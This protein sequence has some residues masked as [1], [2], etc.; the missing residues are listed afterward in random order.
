VS[1]VRTLRWTFRLTIAA[2]VLVGLVLY[3]VNHAVAGTIC[4]F[5][6]I[7]AG[8]LSAVLPSRR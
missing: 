2:C 8:L 1:A 4:F 3:A 6:A 5:A 7:A